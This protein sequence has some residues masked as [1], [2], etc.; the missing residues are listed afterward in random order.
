VV[1]RKYG[2]PFLGGVERR[3]LGNGEA[4]ECAADLEPQV[5]VGVGGVVQVNDEAALARL[6]R[7]VLTFR[8][9]RLVRPKRIAF[10]AILLERIAARYENVRPLCRS[11]PG[12][13]EPLLAFA[14]RAH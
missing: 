6:A 13:D 5:V 8:R 10:F 9:E 4:L 1:F 14:G 3:P 2:E 7:A 12:C 11:F